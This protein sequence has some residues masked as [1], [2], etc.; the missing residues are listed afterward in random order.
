MNAM[1]TT[2]PRAEDIRRSWIVINADDQALG[3]LAVKIADRLRGKHKP[4]YT[5]HVDT[6]DFVVVINARRVKLTGKKNEQKIYADY[7]GYRNGL[8]E[9]KASVMREHNPERMIYDA[10][11]RMLPKNRLMRE[12]FQRLKVYAGDTHPH[13]SQNPQPLV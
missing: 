4:T 2:I 13:A 12:A 1:K 11:K 7:S 5:P 6:G 9:V 8:K 10:V 3:R